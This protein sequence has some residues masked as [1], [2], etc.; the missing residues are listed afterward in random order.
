MAFSM[1]ER[2]RLAEIEERLSS[3]DPHLAGLIADWSSGL[4]RRGVS[5][6]AA[7]V[8]ACVVALVTGVILIGAGDGT[9][10]M[11]AGVLVMVLGVLVLLPALMVGGRVLWPRR[12]RG[13]WNATTRSVRRRG[14]SGQ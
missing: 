9:L 5:E 8:I 2:R 14:P 12:L 10:S 13:E 1:S 4:I 6:V 11:A 7:G 3:E